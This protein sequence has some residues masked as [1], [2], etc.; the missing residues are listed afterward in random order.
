MYI[1]IYR[2]GVLQDWGSMHY[3][4]SETLSKVGEMLK[5]DRELEARDCARAAL[6]ASSRD[7]YMHV[8]TCIYI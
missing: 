2:Q 8:Y 7:V 6:Q 1:C 5:D 3:L 4:H